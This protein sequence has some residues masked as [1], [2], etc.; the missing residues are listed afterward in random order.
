MSAKKSTSSNTYTFRCPQL[1]A[2]K[3]DHFCAKFSID[4]SSLIKIALNHLIY[5][6][7][8][9]N[10]ELIPPQIL[11]NI[12]ESPENLQR[13]LATS[14]MLPNEDSSSLRA[15]ESPSDYEPNK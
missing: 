8:Q 1:I 7:E 12:R 6:I 5:R 3:M 14:E 2:E 4:R 11:L 9:Q 15:A 13:N 10:G